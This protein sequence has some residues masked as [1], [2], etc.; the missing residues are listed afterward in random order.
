MKWSIIDRWGTHPRLVD[1]FVDLINA[2]LQTI[3]PKIRD[4]VIIL[5]S[6]HSLPMKVLNLES[7]IPFYLIFNSLE[8]QS[9]YGNRC[10][11]S[12]WVPIV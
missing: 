5:F 11:K 4:E 2:E 6:A 3:E 1:A 12:K 10:G 9:P 7:N 8:P